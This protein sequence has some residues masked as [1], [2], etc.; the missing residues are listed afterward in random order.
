MHSSASVISYP[1]NPMNCEFIPL[2]AYNERTPQ[3]VW[4]LWTAGQALVELWGQRRWFNNESSTCWIQKDIKFH[5]LNLF[6]KDFIYLAKAPA[7]WQNECSTSHHP[8]YLTTAK[9]YTETTAGHCC[10]LDNRLTPSIVSKFCIDS[11]SSPPFINWL[12]C[13]YSAMVNTCRFQ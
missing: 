11:F 5:N 10:H 2:F 8:Q 12:L 4:E 1:N 3:L 6:I 13:I 9:D 7:N